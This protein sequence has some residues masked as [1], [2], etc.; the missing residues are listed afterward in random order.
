MSDVKALAN[1]MLRGKEAQDQ[2]SILG[3]DGVPVDYH[4]DFW[5]SEF[6]DFTLIQQDFFDDMDR[7]VPI[8]RQ[9]Y[10]LRLVKSICDRE[11]N[12]E[13][14]EEVA[15]GFK[16]IINIVRQMNYTEFESSA[17]RDYEKS[18]DD[19]LG[20]LTSGKPEAVKT[21]SEK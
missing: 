2:I 4:L 16:K 20:E 12:F 19:L 7:F 5:K 6:I 21:G 18:L 3:D 15:P 11:F 9:E 14:F 13:S 8:P 10:S 1:I 17:F